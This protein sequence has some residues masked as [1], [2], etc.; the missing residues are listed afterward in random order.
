MPLWAVQL[1][2]GR[3]ER[4]EADMLA[5]ESG[6]LVA[7]FDEGHF[8]RAWA[9]GQWRTVHLLAGGDAHW[10][11]GEGATVEARFTDDVLVGLPQR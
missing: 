7:L 11:G 8:V 9:S 10:R 3:D 5:I 6:A 2:D 4:V 1:S